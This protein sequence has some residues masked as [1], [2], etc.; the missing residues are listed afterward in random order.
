M[1]FSFASM[2]ILKLALLSLLGIATFANN[3][4][5][6]KLISD[7]CPKTKNP[8]KC[9]DI[10]SIGNSTRPAI[11]LDGLGLTIL[12]VAIF[13]ANLS[14]DAFNLVI[15][16]IK[17]LPTKEKEKYQKCGDGYAGAV[18]K[19]GDAKTAWIKKNYALARKSIEVAND[20]PISCEKELKAIPP[21]LISVTTVNEI[22]HITFE[23]ALV[24]V[25]HLEGTQK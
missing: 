8:K 18:K 21:P 10:L 11:P 20:A 7:I 9:A 25:K 12:D 16:K 2:F 13:Q 6:N 17:N 24:I 22:S 23:I 4:P 5:T 19:L 14:V 3:I 15:I 1:E